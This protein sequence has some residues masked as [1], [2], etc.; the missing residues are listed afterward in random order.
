MSNDII[1][2]LELA[3]IAS[4][5]CMTKT[6][7][8]QQHAANCRYRVLNEAIGQIAEQGETIANLTKI[9][10][11]DLA[12]AEEHRL[13]IRDAEEDLRN[14][15]TSAEAEIRELR[16]RQRLLREALQ[17]YVDYDIYICGP[18]GGLPESDRLQKAQAAL[19]QTQP[20]R[21]VV[22]CSYC[23]T[24]NTA[25]PSQNNENR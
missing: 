17:T 24:T 16:E 9:V 3:C 25:A 21:E 14:Y 12:N 5:Q 20:E 8:F 11:N 18:D 7:D 15:R 22:K 1:S 13:R 23:G 6:P 10:A 2:R 4:C 19:G